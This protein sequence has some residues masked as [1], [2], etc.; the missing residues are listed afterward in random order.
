MAN[1]YTLIQAQNCTSAVP[2]ITFASIPQTYTDLKLVMSW[3]NTAGGT[4]QSNIHLTFNGATDRYYEILFY[5][6]NSTT[7]SVSRQNAY[8]YITWA[9]TGNGSGTTANVFGIQETY[10]PNYKSSSA[11]AVIGT[12]AT[13]NM[14]SVSWMLLTAASWNP[15]SNAPIT[16]LTLTADNNNIAINSSF[17]LYGIKNS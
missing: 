1:T 6:Q 4:E 8:P 13:E 16:S 12:G 14:A 5:G 7:G 9:G 3:R 17:Y 11:K 2:S 10:I 15:T